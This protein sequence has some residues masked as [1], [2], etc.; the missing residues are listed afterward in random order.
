MDFPYQVIKGLFITWI[1]LG[2]IQYNTKDLVDQSV[3]WSI[4][5]NGIENI[6]W[7]MYNNKP[8]ELIN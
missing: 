2:I 3:L 5:T 1:G 4:L 7:T 8:I 6:S